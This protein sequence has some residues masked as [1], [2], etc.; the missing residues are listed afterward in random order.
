MAK[1]SP[2]EQ[3]SDVAWHFRMIAIG[4]FSLA[5]LGVVALV[6]LVIIPLLWR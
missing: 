3:W 2:A 4:C 5:G 6:A 1:K